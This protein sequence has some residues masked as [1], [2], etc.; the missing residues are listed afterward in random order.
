MAEHE[1]D[2][3]IEKTMAPNDLK[4]KPRPAMTPEQRQ[5]V[6]RLLPAAQ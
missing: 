5:V 4:F 3:T 1:Q 2:M 6:G